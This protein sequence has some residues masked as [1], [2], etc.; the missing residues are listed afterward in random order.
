MSHTRTVLSWLPEASSL[1]FGPKA[2]LLTSLRC[3]LSVKSSWKG[4]GPA[5]RVNL[6]G[7]RKTKSKV[8]TKVSRV[9]R[10]LFSLPI[11]FLLVEP[12]DRPFIS[13]VGAQFAAEPQQR[14]GR[15]RHETTH[16]EGP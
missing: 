6:I 2:T 4:G 12:L 10:D 11:V 16:A 1:P 7:P 5:A 13:H 3:P 8:T 9:K 15:G 14:I